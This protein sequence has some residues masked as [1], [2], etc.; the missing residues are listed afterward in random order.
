MCAMFTGPRGSYAH[1]RPVGLLVLILALLGVLSTLGCTSPTDPNPEDPIALTATVWDAAEVP[2]TV[3]LDVT[4]GPATLQAWG[5]YGAAQGS[6]STPA[7]VAQAFGSTE[8]RP[9]GAHTVVVMPGAVG[10]VTFWA[11]AVSQRPVYAFAECP[12]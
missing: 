12:E 3:R 11:A 5:Y 1:L 7:E 9:G 2:C 8:V 6:G 4:G 10:P